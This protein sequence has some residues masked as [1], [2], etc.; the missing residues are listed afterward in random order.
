MWKGERG[1]GWAIVICVYNVF[2]M[3]EGGMEKGWSLLIL[4]Q[5]GN[6][7]SFVF[8][9]GWILDTHSDFDKSQHL[10]LVTF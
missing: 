5:F 1:W 3:G 2:I 4:F 7:I 10:T 8:Y 6:N 9:M